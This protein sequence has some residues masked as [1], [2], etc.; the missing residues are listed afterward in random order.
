MTYILYHIIY[1]LRII[2]KRTGFF[3]FFKK[4]TIICQKLKQFL[5]KNFRTLYLRFFI[6]FTPFCHCVTHMASTIIQKELR[7]H[8]VK[9]SVRG[10]FFFRDSNT[11]FLIRI[12]L[13]MLH[14]F[15][16]LKKIR[17][18]DRSSAP[19][20]SLHGIVITLTLHIDRL[21]DNYISLFRRIRVFM[22]H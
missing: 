22:Y 15:L 4:N 16:R 13:K 6:Y 8:T 2:S 11:Y 9:I 7:F 20:Y 17:K 18:H 3:F 1:I 14:F 10:T 12:H 21:L 5:S 19:R